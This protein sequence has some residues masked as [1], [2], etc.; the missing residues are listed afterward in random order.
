M[1]KQSGIR[2]KWFL[3][4]ILVLMLICMSV[5]PTIAQKEEPQHLSSEDD[6]PQHNVYTFSGGKGTA[7]DPYIISSVDDL[8]VFTEAVKNENYAQ[9]YYRL[10]ANIDLGN[11][12]WTT[13]FCE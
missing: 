8:L 1:Y 3:S 10:T 6:E 4:L 9:S 5:I 7:Q 2:F 12:L 13:P 11:N